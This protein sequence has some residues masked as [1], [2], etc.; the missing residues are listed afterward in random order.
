[1]CRATPV[2]SSPIRR[3]LLCASGLLLAGCGTWERKPVDI[4]PEDMCASCKMSVSDQRFASEIL[5]ESGEVFKFDDPGCLEE[6]R[7]VHPDLKI[8]AKFVKD[9]EG[10]TWLRWEDAVI[11]TTGLFTPM[12][13]GKVAVRDSSR[14]REI[15][16]QHPPQTVRG[17]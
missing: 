9:Y 2:H 15:L 8:A 1:M 4:F 12:G 3:L 14:A 10:G 11:V 17:N 7:R 6:Y 5:A 13:S 16:R